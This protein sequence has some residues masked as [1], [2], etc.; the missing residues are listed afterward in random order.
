MSSENTISNQN[1]LAEVGLLLNDE[2]SLNMNLMRETYNKFNSVTYSTEELNTFKD[3]ILSLLKERDKIFLNK[4][5]DYKTSTDKI[6]FEFNSE[7]KLTNSKF[8]KIIDTQAKMTSRLDQLSDYENFVTKTKEKLVSHDIRLTNIRNDFSLATQ[9]YD[10]I[11]LDNLELPGYIGRCAKY[12]NCQSFFL[13]V[14]KDLAKLNIYREKNILDLKMY[15][16]KLE[17]IISSMNS[18]LD[19]N[20]ESQIKYINEMKEKILK[21]CKSMF[22]DVSDGMKDIRVENSKYAVDLISTS[23][24]LSKK[25]EKLEKIKEELLEKFNYDVNKYQMLTDDT[26]KSFEEFKNEYGVIRR[27]FMELAEFIKDIR[28]RKNIGGNVK[29][30]EV[31]QMVKKMLKKRKSFEGEKVQ[32]LSD[33][34]IIENIDYKKYYNIESNDEAEINNE[35]NGE[36]KNIHNR[37]KSLKPKNKKLFNNN[38]KEKENEKLNEK[39]KEKINSNKISKE[40]KQKKEMNQS[41]E[42]TRV[43]RINMNN[44]SV[45]KY[46]NIDKEKEKN[47]SSRSVNMNMKLNISNSMNNKKNSMNKI[48]QDEKNIKNNLI[49]D[50]KNLKDEENFDQKNKEMNKSN[51]NKDS[52][53][54]KL[55]KNNTNNNI[56]LRNILDDNSNKYTDK[57]ENTTIPLSH[58]DKEKNIEKENVTNTYNTN[59]TNNINNSSANNKTNN[60]INYELN[61]IKLNNDSKPSLIEDVSTISDVKNSSSLNK[62]NKFSSEKSVS[63]ISDSNG[64]NINKFIINDIHL[65]QND[66]IIKELASE[67]EQSTAKKDKFEQKFKT[68]CNNIEPINL[69]ANNKIS[70]NKNNNQYQPSNNTKIEINPNNIN[71]NGQINNQISNT[72]NIEI[73]RD[74]KND[75]IIKENNSDNMIKENVIN[76]N[77]NINNININSK[78]PLIEN[79]CSNNKINNNIKINTN[80]DDINNSNTNSNINNSNNIEYN[81]NSNM[82]NPNN[83]VKNESIG[84]LNPI[85]INNEIHLNEVINSNSVNSKLH[86]FDQKLLN[87]ELYTKEKIIEIISQIN[88][89]K[90]NGSIPESNK[91]ANNN[92]NDTNRTILVPNMTPLSNEKYKTFNTSFINSQNNK[93]THHNSFNIEKSYPY[94]SNPTNI[95]NNKNIMN[96]N[97]NITNPNQNLLFN[98]NNFNTNFNPDKKKYSLRNV[99]PKQAL[100]NSKIQKKNSFSYQLNTSNSINKK[101]PINSLTEN[102]SNNNNNSSINNNINNLGINNN[103]NLF[104]KNNLNMN[105]I[106]KQNNTKEIIENTGTKIIHNVNSN[107]INAKFLKD[108]EK[109]IENNTN[110]LLKPNNI[111]DLYVKKPSKNMNTFNP[112]RNN[113]N[114]SSFNGAEIKLVDLNKLVN[115]QLPRNRLV[116]IH[117]NENDYFEHFISNK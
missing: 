71:N 107:E 97:N 46:S 32:L 117:I 88:S 22:E 62:D 23:M 95:E 112:N 94:E 8:S 63:F 98:N 1:P 7:N 69:L 21:D 20:N 81:K 104:N 56:E 51:K 33:I 113:Y 57:L 30:K 84:N 37:S 19:N 114:D 66:K 82:N 64:N 14:I 49:I 2:A 58:R 44:S 29:K 67:L 34:T 10:K 78:T 61:P 76:S 90:Q 55:V 99:N 15:K 5:S 28:F 47:K 39:N 13:D 31:K 4:L 40:I 42:D 73:N 24:N 89:L 54:I 41:V 11:Y 116:P 45:N 70:E 106:L 26:I 86:A 105:N 17:T 48:T 27:K 35:S 115:H 87:L 77:N 3:N 108:I 68:A 59:N 43:P 6:K 72:N 65:E 79:E 93:L 38:I 50:S 53:I 92:N 9:K 12:K 103:N 52:N 80:I 60:I 75:I 85:K 111:E 100:I 110:S 83:I 36:E 18:I 96:I 25:W 16:D 74:K 91:A 102:N 109:K 101:L